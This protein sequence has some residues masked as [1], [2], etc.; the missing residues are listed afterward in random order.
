MPRVPDYFDQNIVTSTSELQQHS[1]VHKIYPSWHTLPWPK[2]T[3]FALNLQWPG[4]WCKLP[5]GHSLY[6]VTFHLEQMD[7]DW[8]RELAIREPNSKVLVITDNP[9]KHSDWWPKNCVTACWMTWHHQ[10]NAIRGLYGM[11]IGPNAPTH[12]V[13]SLCFRT[14]QYKHYI[15]GYLLQGIQPKDA[16]MSYHARHQHR[17]FFE[18]TGRKRLDQVLEYMHQ[19]NPHLTVDGFDAAQNYPMA[20][21]D[22][23]VPAYTDAAINFTN[24][25]FHYSYSIRDGHD[26]YWPGPY[27]T[28]KT[29]KPLLAGCAFVAVGQANIHHTL[30]SLGFCFDYGIDLGHD[31]NIYDLDRLELLFDVVDAVLS[32]SAQEL[33]TLTSS[34]TQHNLNWIQNGQFDLQC[35][36]RNKTELAV[37]EHF[38]LDL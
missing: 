33:T 38:L 19:T 1:L 4:T 29:W 37:L 30:R 27:V 28:E 13:S 24:E 9:C 20:N 17:Y 21:C 22:W 18:P 35:Q 16:I 12:K 31:Q 14:D 25:G 15:T 8:V 7:V 23:R 26:F 10:I 5:Q 3:V 34:S 11:A 36:S 6:V 2:D 32:H